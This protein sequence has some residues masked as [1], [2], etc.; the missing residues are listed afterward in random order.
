MTVSFKTAQLRRGTIAY[1]SENALRA[2]PN[3]GPAIAKKLLRLGIEQPA[4]L[5]GQDPEQLF[6]RLCDLDGRR[7]D[8]CLLD[9]FVAA[10][11]HANGAPARPWWYYSRQR[12]A[13]ADPQN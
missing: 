7:H 8:P 1:M 11:D 6:R 10:V 9:T 3:I 5:R 4:D 2:L 12:K 13:G